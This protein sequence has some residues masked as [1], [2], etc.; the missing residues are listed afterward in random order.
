MN[1]FSLVEKIGVLMNLISSS[2]L[3]LIAL[4]VVIFLLVLFIVCTLMNKKINKFIF[5]SAFCV[6]GIMFVINYWSVIIKILD[7]II[8]SAF[9]ALYFPSLPIYASVLLISNI[10]FIITIFNK[11]QIKS[12]KILD[13]VNSI[14]LDFLLI[15]II[16]IVSKNNINIYEEIT[17]YTNSNLLVLLE[18][19]MGVFTSWILLNLFLSA[20]T[21]LKKYDKVE[22]PKMPEIIF[23]EF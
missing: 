14:V 17:L 2:P 22:Y 16:D 11:K 8:D 21:K 6:I 19:S 18:L 12:K 5:I 7:A 20:H 23:D 4:F 1:D 10:C 13:I 3:F 15:L 9:M